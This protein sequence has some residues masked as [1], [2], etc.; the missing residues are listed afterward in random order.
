MGTAFAAGQ[1][2]ES[3]S[4]SEIIQKQAEA[5]ET[6]ANASLA[7]VGVVR[8][9]VLVAQYQS[10]TSKQQLNLNARGVKIMD[11]GLRHN[12]ESNISLTIPVFSIVHGQKPLAVVAAANLGTSSVRDMRMFA[13]VSMRPPDE[14]VAVNAVMRFKNQ[15]GALAKGQ[16]T[17]APIEFP[18]VVDDEMV[19]NLRH[20]KLRLYAF[21][22][23]EFRDALGLHR[24][25]VCAY[26]ASDDFS[27]LR[28]CRF[29]GQGVKLLPT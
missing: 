24:I 8:R 15:R 7:Q 11:E 25:H 29:P 5:A 10:D 3:Y 4:S 2:F 13:N 16:S 20:D 19:E 14:M 17:G 18:D 23:I 12:L 6:L 1:W 27:K 26:A 21:G 9:L 28:W 22:A